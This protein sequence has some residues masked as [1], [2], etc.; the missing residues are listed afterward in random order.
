[1]QIDDSRLDF[2]FSEKA[3]TIALEVDLLKWICKFS[4]RMKHFPSFSLECWRNARKFAAGTMAE[5]I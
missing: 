5:G 4:C 2:P 1:M 3:S